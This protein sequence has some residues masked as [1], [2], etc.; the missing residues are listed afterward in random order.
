MLPDKVHIFSPHIDDA[1]LSLGGCIIN[2]VGKGKEVFVDNIFT[3]TNWT[4]PHPI[5]GLTYPCSIDDV[6]GLRKAEEKKV[7]QALNITCDFLDLPDHPVRKG[8]S[9]YKKQKIEEC[10]CKHVESRLDTSKAFFIPLGL[11]HPD[12]LFLNRIVKEVIGADYYNVFYYEDLPYYS[13]GTL[14]Y[15][16]HFNQLLTTKKAFLEKVLQDSK[17]EIL[18]HYSSQ[19]TDSFFQSMRAYAYEKKDNCYYERYWAH[20]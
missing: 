1:V 12:H 9:R 14:D 11:D 7:A 3:K 5:S 19:L 4:H 15:M 2:W 6:T 16:A 17:E 20:I 10:L 18:R 8:Y 13:W